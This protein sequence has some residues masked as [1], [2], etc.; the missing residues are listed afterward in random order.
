MAARA[1][2]PADAD[3][4]IREV[5]FAT[6]MYGGVSLAI[7]INGVAQEL[8]RMV[9]ATAPREDGPTSY[10]ADAE[11]DGSERVYREI[12]RRLLGE[13]EWLSGELPSDAPI[14][15]R[16]IA[17][18]LSGT[19]A[20]GI[21]AI[22]LAKAL[23][24]GQPFD[25][26]RGLWVEEADIGVLLNE[27]RAYAGLAGRYVKPPQSLLT[28]PRL[29][30]R[31]LAA[32]RGMREAAAPA[33]RPRY[34]EQIDLAIT[35]T[36]LQGLWLPMRLADG[37]VREPRH[38]TV[39]RFVYSTL[40]ATGAERNDFTAD[41]DRMLALAARATSSFP[42]A[43]EPVLPGDALGSD[44][45]APGRT[46]FPDHAREQVP[47]RDWA[48]ADGGY[49]DNKPFTQATEALRRRRADVP[50]DR[51]L[52]YIE[53][54][55]SRVPDD[56]NVPGGRPDAV[57]AVGAAVMLPRVEPIRED[58]AALLSRN[59]TIERVRR[60]TRGIE[61]AALEPGTRI[62]PPAPVELAYLRLRRLEVIEDLTALV[63][64]V[65]GQP[66][67]GDEAHFASTLLDAWAPG[68]DEA[69]GQSRAAIRAFLDAYDLS[70]RL[71]RLSLLQDRLT[72]LLLR[73][74][75][76]ELLS[77]AG[78]TISAEQAATDGAVWLR[79]RKAGLNDQFVTLRRIG[80]RARARGAAP[81]ADAPTAPGGL[82]AALARFGFGTAAVD[83]VVS[84][85]DPLAAAR[86]LL[87]AT[88]LAAAVTAFD[89][90]L[91]TQFGSALPD[92]DAA[93]GPELARDVTTEV[94][95]Q[96]SA[97]LTSYLD[98]VEPVDMA[99]FPL[100]YPDLREANPVEVFRISP[101]DAPSLVPVGS[102]KRRLAGVAIGHFGGFLDRR[103]R[104][105]DLL[106]GRLDGSERLIAALVPAP[107]DREPL[108]VRAHAAILREE[109]RRTPGLAELVR[110]DARAQLLEL[111]AHDDTP[112]EQLVMCFSA[113][114][115][116]PAD[117]DD[118]VKLGL[119][120]RAV[121]ITGHVLEGAA[122]RHGVVPRPLRWVMRAVRLAVTLAVALATRVA[123]LRQR[124]S[125]N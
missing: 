13:H 61:I 102:G 57:A 45:A 44:A 28:G 98:C 115:E 20:G 66:A 62:Q 10:L 93:V 81:A 119:A 38:R 56:R 116:G 33:A 53:P 105:S 17:D 91:R 12:G 68:G 84:A 80:R 75:S 37:T 41:N 110:P 94:E 58:L 106:W 90:A 26:L 27:P 29:Y 92:A 36:D 14:L 97:L 71:R 100:V 87:A 52:L 108:R 21:N 123:R 113:A 50:V 63:V 3:E 101:Q 107:A 99:I 79:A 121:A 16:F 4:P 40:G 103:W 47:W 22:Y 82:A 112:P 59:A 124:I 76:A 49:L 117:L 1:S 73:R 78:C 114:Y 9:R 19:S 8:F 86:E 42:F 55:P 83:T 109:L 24:N 51:K 64:R 15:T 77:A 67:D 104:E 25:P 72:D 111:A 120:G 23:A 88:D 34:V 11:L 31:A 118:A 125:S 18:I 2:T 7:Y 6:V 85:T 43:F 32:L 54:D 69:A 122:A 30:D 74:R 70:F 95:R 89:D 35:T 96:L 5:R 46:F 65:A 48:F 39:L 60:V